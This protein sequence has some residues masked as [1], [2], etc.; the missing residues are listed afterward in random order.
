MSLDLGQTM[1]MR[2]FKDLGQ[3]RMLSHTLL[4]CV[5]AIVAVTLL[6]WYIRQV[7]LMCDAYLQS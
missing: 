7:A 6:S 1:N 4:H 5:P 3:V 2:N